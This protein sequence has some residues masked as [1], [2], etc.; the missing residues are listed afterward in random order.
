[1]RMVMVQNFCRFT[2]ERS[3]SNQTERVIAPYA[4]CHMPDYCKASP[5]VPTALSTPE[6][7]PW[8]IISPWKAQ[9]LISSR[10]S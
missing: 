10:S 1:M 8:M 9:L 4:L 2:K 3:V 5:H 6:G 7:L